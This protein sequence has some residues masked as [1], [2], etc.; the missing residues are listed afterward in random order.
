MYRN[1]RSKMVSLMLKPMTPSLDLIPDLPAVMTFTGN[2]ILTNQ[3]TVFFWSNTSKVICH[4]GII[5]STPNK[6]RRGDLHVKALPRPGLKG[7][8][9]SFPNRVLAPPIF[10]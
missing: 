5:S 3:G 9:F 7:P 6:G 8:F 2:V 1:Q 4:A 10:L